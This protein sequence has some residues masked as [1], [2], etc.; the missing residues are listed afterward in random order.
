VNKF[1]PVTLIIVFIF[2]YGCVKAS[3]YPE[4]I[5]EINNTVEQNSNNDVVINEIDTNAHFLVDVEFVEEDNAYKISI[6][7][8]TNSNLADSNALS[9][10]QVDI[11]QLS[12]SE[13]PETYKSWIDTE[14]YCIKI[15]IIDA[16]LAD[17]T[18][19]EK[20]IR[21]LNGKNIQ[22]RNSLITDIDL[23]TV[24]ESVTDILIGLTRKAEFSVNQADAGIIVVDILK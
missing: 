12:F 20:T 9:R 1:G 11:K 3:S 16:V 24:E 14:D 21:L 2:L 7:I 23:I 15:S 6:P 4:N 13:V 10:P 17:L 8:K 18:S 5:A 22:V 19:L